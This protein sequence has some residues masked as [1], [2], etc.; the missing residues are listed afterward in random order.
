MGIF[1]SA[2]VLLAVVFLT[3]WGVIRGVKRAKENFS[4]GISSAQD[5]VRE[6]RTESEREADENKKLNA[7]Q[8]KG[9]DKIEQLFG[10]FN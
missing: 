1:I 4:Y 6:I 10:K 2:V 8:E 7:E 5:K 9:L 3:I